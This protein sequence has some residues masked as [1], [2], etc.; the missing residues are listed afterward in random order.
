MLIEFHCHTVAE[1][2][3]LSTSIKNSK[4]YSKVLRFG[5]KAQSSVLEDAEKAIQ[6]NITNIA[7]TERLKEKERL[8]VDTDIDFETEQYYD[9][10]CPHCGEKLSFMS[11][12][13]DEHSNVTCPVCDREF[14]VSFD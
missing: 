10:E 8:N 3:N 4:N 2:Y 12:Q 5:S 9:F 14:K 1:L 13:A 6:E 7:M 11:W